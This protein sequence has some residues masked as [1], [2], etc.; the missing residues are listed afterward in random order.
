MKTLIRN[1]TVVLPQGTS[2]VSVLI[3]G[4]QL[5]DID[6]AIQVS[7]DE[8]VD[9]TGL[10]LLPGVVDDQVHFREP[11]LT[12][13]EDLHHASRACAKGGVTTFLE[14]PNTIPNTKPRPSGR[15]AHV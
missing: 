13:K 5:A 8:V 3:D 15:L 1:A 4:T 11:G 2:S 9:A 12:H 6:P 7:A 10:H 14:M